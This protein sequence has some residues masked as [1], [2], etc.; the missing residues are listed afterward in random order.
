MFCNAR[1]MTEHKKPEKPE[2]PT[3]KTHSE[4]QFG[5]NGHWA[6]SDQPWRPSYIQHGMSGVGR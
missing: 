2:K 3:R 1:N 4:T 6:G 5:L